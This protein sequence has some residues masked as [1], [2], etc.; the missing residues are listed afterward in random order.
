MINFS[1]PSLLFSFKLHS[2]P[3]DP[4]NPEKMSTS[5]STSA[6]AIKHRQIA[7]LAQQFQV[8]ATRAEQMERL[9]L[10]TAEQASY[11][12]LL[13]GYHASW[14]ATFSVCIDAMTDMLSL[15]LLFLVPHLYS[16]A[17]FPYFS[18]CIPSTNVR[19][20]FTQKVHCCRSG[21][22]CAQRH[23]TTTA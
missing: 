21:Y 1:P 18:D 2:F 17:L 13:G 4:F 12:R 16:L 19:P 22:D 20:P 8:L 7:H 23:G 5:Q 6:L 9:T 15:F 14:Y 11:L 3:L 10:T